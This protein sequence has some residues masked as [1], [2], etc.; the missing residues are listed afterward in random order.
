LGG[1]KHSTEQCREAWL[2]GMRWTPEER[3]WVPL[4]L[5]LSPP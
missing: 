4:V 1:F 3:T 5:S 2:P